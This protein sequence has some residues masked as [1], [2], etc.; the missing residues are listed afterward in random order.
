MADHDEGA[1]K[2]KKLLALGLYEENV[3]LE[4]EGKREN[5]TRPFRF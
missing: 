5:F 4:K 1:N 2:E 3:N